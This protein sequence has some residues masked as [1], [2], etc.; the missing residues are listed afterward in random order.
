[1]GEP[2]TENLQASVTSEQQAVPITNGVSE[3]TPEQLAARC[4]APV[5]KEFLRSPPVRSSSA[6]Q[7]EEVTA[8][9]D[10]DSAPSGLAKEKKSKRQLKRERREVFLI[11]LS[12]KLRHFMVQILELKLVGEL[13]SL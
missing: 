2:C 1:M 13:S 12:R 4:I 10:K 8:T 6:N 11:F 7:N 9:K 5:K 3:Q